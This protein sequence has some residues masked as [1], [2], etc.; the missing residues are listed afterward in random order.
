MLL[1]RMSGVLD[2]EQTGLREPIGWQQRHNPSQTHWRWGR[3]VFSGLGSTAGRTV[4]SGMDIFCTGGLGATGGTGADLAASLGE[5]SSTIF[6]NLGLLAGTGGGSDVGGPR[7]DRWND[8]SLSQFLEVVI[9]MVVELETELVPWPGVQGSGPGFALSRKQGCFRRLGTVGTLLTG[10][11]LILRGVA[12]TL[13]LGST[14]LRPSGSFLASSGAGPVSRRPRLGGGGG[15]K[16]LGLLEVKEWA[17][18]KSEKAGFR[19]T[20]TGGGG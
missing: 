13:R 19:G 15:S 7:E 8:L 20:G 3:G 11:S 10:G 12:G 1:L 4:T 6:R 18:G 14:R 17:R 9:A 5:A 2:R 16:G